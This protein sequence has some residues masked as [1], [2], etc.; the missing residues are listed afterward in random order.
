M[1]AVLLKMF[2]TCFFSLYDFP[3][4][5]CCIFTCLEADVLTILENRNNLN[6]KFEITKTYRYIALRLLHF[7]VCLFV[8]I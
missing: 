3:G 5:L 1:F 4:G 7:F 8:F 6:R 2:S